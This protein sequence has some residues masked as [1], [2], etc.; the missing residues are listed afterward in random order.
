MTHRVSLACL[1]G[2]VL[3][4]GASAASA[5]SGTILEDP[6]V[7]SDRSRRLAAFG[8]GTEREKTLTAAW[9]KA[10]KEFAEK[11]DAHRLD[12]RQELRRANKA[13]V[14]SVLNRCVGSDLQWEHDLLLKQ[15]DYTTALPDIT[16][17]VRKEVLTALGAFTDAEETMIRGVDA[18]VFNTKDSLV[19][20]LKNLHTKYRMPL[21]SAWIKASVDR[22]LTHSALVTG[23]E[24]QTGSGS[25]MSVSLRN[26]MA[27]AESAMRSALKSTVNAERAAS[28]LQNL[29]NCATPDW[30][31]GSGTTVP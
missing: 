15:K 7:M 9:V 4:L 28:L 6:S 25:L 21:H 31:T 1:L 29:G 10:R 14:V 20:A 5:S 24:E 22:A 26:C 3:F 12:C 18:G 30:G 8:D 23:T 11:R 13:Q 16:Q 19:T 2:L 27:D 17:P